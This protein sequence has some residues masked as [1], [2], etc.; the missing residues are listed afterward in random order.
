ML[1]LTQDSCQLPKRWPLIVLKEIWWLTFSHIITIILHCV[2]I[3]LHHKIS[4]V[5][6]K[7]S[8]FLVP[9]FILWPIISGK[10][11]VAGVAVQYSRANKAHASIINRG[12]PLKEGLL[13]PL[14]RNN[15][16]KATD[17]ELLPSFKENLK[18][19]AYIENLR[20]KFK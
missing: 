3:F 15:F 12:S 13:L 18:N 10:V 19:N 17:L 9:S 16:I 6:T 7:Q 8:D 14:F 2:E 20:K 11:S 5:V 1:S 4:V